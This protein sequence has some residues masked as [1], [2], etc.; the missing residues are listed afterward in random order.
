[1]CWEPFFQLIIGI[2][3][4][5]WIMPLHR[6]NNVL[7]KSSSNMNIFTNVRVNT[8]HHDWGPSKFE[9]HI[10]PTQFLNQHPTYGS[11]Y[12]ISHSKGY[13]TY[14]DIINVRNL[15]IH[16]PCIYA[17]LAQFNNNYTHTHTHTQNNPNVGET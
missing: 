10:F 8:M 2:G 16:V 17:T 7:K 9:F 12:R 6:I 5:L 4:C 11:Q 3:C 14:K 15:K 1:L 13:D